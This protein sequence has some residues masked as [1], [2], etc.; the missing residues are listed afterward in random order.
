[1]ARE[2]CT[3]SISMSGWSLGSS[4][5]LCRSFSRSNPQRTIVRGS[6]YC[7]FVPRDF[8]PI[9]VEPLFH[10]KDGILEMWKTRHSHGSR[11]DA[12]LCSK[13]TFLSA[14]SRRPLLHSPR[15]HP[16]IS[17]VEST[18]DSRKHNLSN[19]SLFLYPTREYALTTKRIFAFARNNPSLPLRKGSNLYRSLLPIPPFVLV[20]K[21][22]V[23]MTSPLPL[24][25]LLN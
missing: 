20:T 18:Q 25:A 14:P 23:L 2:M 1:M 21:D 22:T 9:K 13:P 3:I 15:S 6:G 24:G 17:K 11:C 4:F 19:P 12:V 16:L 5:P 8:M 10:I 7:D